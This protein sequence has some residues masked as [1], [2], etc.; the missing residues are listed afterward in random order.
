MV[1]AVAARTTR[2]Q[3]VPILLAPLYE[4]I[5]LAED[6]AVV[7]V[8]SGGRVNPLIGAGYVASEFE[9]FAKHL[10]A[11]VAAQEECVAVLKQ[12]WT[13]EPFTYRG[14]TVRVT[15]RPHQQPRPLITLG[16]MSPGA[17]RRAARIAD[18]F[19][20]AEPGNWKHYV[21][22]CAR[23]GRD[24]GPH[25]RFGPA[26]LYVTED[27]EAAWR[28]VAPYL[29][30]NIA[31]YERWTREGYRSSFTPF[32]GIHDLAGLQS[33]PA[34]QVLTPDEC[35]E[36]AHRFD[37]EAGLLFHPLMADSLLTCHGR[38]WSSSPTRFFPSC[39]P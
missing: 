36:F 2:L 11:R 30:H 16:G 7:D 35:V 34:F 14:R 22:E 5:R 27:P 37:P 4:P 1:A 38:A 25:E 12:A 39:L 15:P 23:L 24:P 13:G 17:A 33:A 20:A 31:A 8:I 10:D 19:V 18:R 3:L 29:L 9:M 6:I 21:A 32:A 28:Q 26:F